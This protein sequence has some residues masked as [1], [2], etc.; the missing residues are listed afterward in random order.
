M[1]AGWMLNTHNTHALH[2]HY[3]TPHQVIAQY[4]LDRWSATGNPMRAP[5]P[6]LRAKAALA[7]R[8]HDMYITTIQV[9]SV[10]CVV[11]IQSCVFSNA[12][13]AQ[14]GMY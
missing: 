6:E 5:T 7:T 12:G 9:R 3:T 13:A 4:I 10:L 11:G 14:L 2:T 8:V 1:L